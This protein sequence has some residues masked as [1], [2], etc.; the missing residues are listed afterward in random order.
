[1]NKIYKYAFGYTDTPQFRDK[2]YKSFIV[3]SRFDI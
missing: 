2:I 1:M 3:Y